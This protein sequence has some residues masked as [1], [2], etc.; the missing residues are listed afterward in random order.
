M[1]HGQTAYKIK[2]NSENKKNI[3]MGHTTSAKLRKLAKITAQ[4]NHQLK[5][6]SRPA[7]RSSKEKNKTNCI[8]YSILNR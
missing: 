4:Q 2:K 8:E 6:C 5:I 3:T 7:Q 1:F